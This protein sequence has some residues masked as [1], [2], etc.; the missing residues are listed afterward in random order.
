MPHTVSTK[1][2][3]PNA[4]VIYEINFAQQKANYKINQT[5]SATNANESDHFLCHNFI[6]FK[7]RDF[8]KFPQS[9][10]VKNSNI[11]PTF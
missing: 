5:L 8:L 7:S 2:R 3:P 9:H 4:A 1:F 6:R 11:M 10:T